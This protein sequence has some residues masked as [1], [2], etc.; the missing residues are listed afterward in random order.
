[1]RAPRPPGRSIGGGLADTDFLLSQG[2]PAFASSNY[3]G[4]AASVGNDGIT[5]SL[6]A[7]T[8]GAD[9]DFFHTNGDNQP[10][11][12]VGQPSRGS[13]SL[14]TA[15][16]TP[17]PTTSQ[18]SNR[19]QWWG[20]DLGGVAAVTRVVI[21]NRDCGGNGVCSS[22]SRHARGWRVAC[23]VGQCAAAGNL[24]AAG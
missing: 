16:P 9:S 23:G 4:I 3:Q 17:T 14:L 19:L 11:G 6:K 5:A 18:T 8:G 7:G 24:R 10:V 22:E 20:V 1:M 12:R 2:Q 15:Y 21:Y 13:V